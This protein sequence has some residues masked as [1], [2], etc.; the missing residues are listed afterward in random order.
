MAEGTRPTAQASSITAAAWFQRQ[1]QSG[2]SGQRGSLPVDAL[3]LDATVERVRALLAAGRGGQIVTL[4]P[5]AVMRA[6]R[7]PGL[8]RIIRE[9]ALVTPDGVGVV[10]ALRLA[11]A[12]V[13][14]RVTG[15]DLIGAL[16]CPLA[17]DG[18][19]VYLLGGAPGVAERAAA[20][21]RTLGP[22]L[23][24]AGCWDGSPHPHHDAEAVARIQA[25][26]AR[27]AL[28][29]YGSPAQDLWIARNRG[30]LGSVVAI[31]VGGAFD[32]LAGETPRAPRWMRARGVEWLYRLWLQP[33]RWRRMLA[34]P[35]FAWWAIWSAALARP[36]RLARLARLG[37]VSVTRPVVARSIS[38][39]GPHSRP[40]N[41]LGD[42]E[43]GR[44]RAA[45]EVE[46]W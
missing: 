38:Q 46:R 24:V 28:V 21:L 44:A 8:A 20:A 3:A 29:A 42:H 19:A 41:R 11:G 10:W 12:P 26:G 18:D 27:L 6:R 16:A 36:A 45:I 30:A 7:D 23:L 33:A 40:E 15:I 1:S 43:T 5:E 34:L 25:S 39:K 31:G 2:Q 17:Q 13:P 32:M 9:A 4:N 22:D 14:E 37:S 35:A